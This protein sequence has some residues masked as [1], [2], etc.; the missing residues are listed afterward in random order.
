MFD[1]ACEWKIGVAICWKHSMFE[2]G[3]IFPVVSPSLQSTLQI[4]SSQS[5]VWMSER[6]P[7]LLRTGDGPLCGHLDPLFMQVW[8]NHVWGTI[9]FSVGSDSAETPWSPPQPWR[10]LEYLSTYAHV[11]YYPRPKINLKKNILKKINLKATVGSMEHWNFDGA[12]RYAEICPY[13]VRKW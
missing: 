11:D 3:H 4:Y 12:N 13:R 2:T 6:L 1:P 10:H 9:S 8:A 7:R 5:N